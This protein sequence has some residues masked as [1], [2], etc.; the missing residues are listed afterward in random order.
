VVVNRRALPSSE[1]PR[2]DR[3]SGFIVVT[4]E[5]GGHKKTTRKKITSVRSSN[6]QPSP[7]CMSM[8]KTRDNEK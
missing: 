4:D 2:V 7:R 5:E 3:A 1:S 8:E 6:R